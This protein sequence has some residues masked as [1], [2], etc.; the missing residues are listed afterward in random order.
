MI[1]SKIR[2]GIP[3]GTKIPINFNSAT[4]FNGP[5]L[6]PYAY[7]VKDGTL[8]I[9]G[10]VSV[11]NVIPGGGVLPAGTTVRI[12]GTGFNTTTELKPDTL[13]ISNFRYISPNEVRFE[14]A[15]SGDITAQRLILKNRSNNDEATYYSYLRPVRAGA[16]ARAL[17]NGADPMFQ[18]ATFTSAAPTVPEAL[19]GGYAGL[20]I[21][22]GT[23]ASTSV[24]MYLVSAGGA[25]LASASQVL[26]GGGRY[27]RSLDE[28]FI[29]AAPAGSS[30]R[31]VSSGPVQVLGLIGNDLQQ[32]VTAFLAAEAP[33]IQAGALT[34]NQQSVQFNHRI[35][36]PLF[37]A[38]LVE[39]GA[40]GTALAFSATPSASWI[41]VD[42]V[43]GQTPGNLGVT[44][45]PAGLSPGQYNGSVSVSSPSAASLNIPVSLTVTAAQGGNSATGLRFVPVSPCRLVDTHNAASAFG[46]PSL[47]ANSARSFAPPQASCGIPA[48]VRRAGQGECRLSAGRL[49]RCGER[50]C[51]RRD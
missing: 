18:P 13:L 33:P 5:G 36:D 11:T 48:A 44:Y 8:T 35:G 25:V 46:A 42:P 27:T 45:N 9:G 22:N 20:S 47:A 4:I 51:H 38:A 6:Q 19:A 43:S 23:L 50:V 24:N 12:L 2:V 31:I 16:S 10:S 1:A 37:S 41:V 26:G 7:L 14:M 30:V 29:P 21:L 3:T 34:A 15:Q 40:T 32:N 17:L 39:I 28:V 49:G